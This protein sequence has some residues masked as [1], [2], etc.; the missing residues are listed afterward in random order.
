MNGMTKKMLGLTLIASV[1]YTF[2]DTQALADYANL[3]DAKK[4][5]VKES[6][7]Q[8]NDSKTNATP[9]SLK[10]VKK[11]EFKAKKETLKIRLIAVYKAA[12]NG[13]VKGWTSLRS[14]FSKI[15]TWVSNGFAAIKTNTTKYLSKLVFW[16]RA[17]TT[18]TTTTPVAPS[19]PTTTEQP[20]TVTDTTVQA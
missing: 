16:K 15:M 11:E 4:A 6:L 12:K 19:T 3:N 14:V 8:V 20:T 18:T 17:Q 1:S 10:D 9:S 13:A 2:A 7:S 5:E